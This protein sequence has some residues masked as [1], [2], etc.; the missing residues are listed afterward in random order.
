MRGFPLFANLG[1]NGELARVP[2]GAESRYGRL[3]LW[4]LADH[5]GAHAALLHERRDG[6][7]E[8]CADGPVCEML[9]YPA[10]DDHR[11]TAP[12]AD[13][14]YSTAWLDVSKE[15]FVL[16][17]PDMH[18]RYFLMPMLDGFTNVFQVPGKRTTGTGAQKYLIS[19]PGWNGTVP[20]GV[21]QYKSPTGLVWI[22]GPHLPHRNAAKTMR[23]STPS[24]R[25]YPSFR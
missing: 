20:A 22:L 14:L 2:R 21:T 15:P 9:S 23:P 12:N 7:P 18:G 8:Q 24:K 3:R 1:T 5:D 17:I 6:I 13:T 19:G 10:V 11:V 16:S 4:I 25:S